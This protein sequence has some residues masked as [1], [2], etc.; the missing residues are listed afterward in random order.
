M[1][2]YSAVVECAKREGVPVTHIGPAMGKNRAYV[3]GG[4]NQGGAPRADTLAKML[5]IC[6]YALCAVPKSLVDES[7]VRIDAV[8]LRDSRMD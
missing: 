3:S 4:V 7:M 8:R 6:G 5:E 1:D 2:A